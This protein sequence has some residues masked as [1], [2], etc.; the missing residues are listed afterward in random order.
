MS[1]SVTV[2]HIFMISFLCISFILSATSYFLT[3][4]N[5]S[6]NDFETDE[7]KNSFTSSKNVSLA[8]MILL[9]F[10]IISYLYLFFRDNKSDNLS[11]EN[12]FLGIS[13][14]CTMN[15]CNDSSVLSITEY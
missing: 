15:T 4:Q 3:T 6:E 8:T 2:L 1:S 10:T 9:L 14:R 13:S 11:N 7:K 5:L 12:R